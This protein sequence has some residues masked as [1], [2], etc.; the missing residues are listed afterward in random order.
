MLCSLKKASHRKLF[1]LPDYVDPD[2][3]YER[4][5][6]MWGEEI[7]DLVDRGEFSTPEDADYYIRHT[8]ED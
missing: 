8:K 1:D 2:E 7:A 4:M 5:R 6:E 3:V